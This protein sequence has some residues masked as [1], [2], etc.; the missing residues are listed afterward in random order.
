VTRH[1]R[2]D[3]DVSVPGR[4]RGLVEGQTHGGVE[5]HEA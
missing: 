5:I 1:D 3:R 2:P 4:G